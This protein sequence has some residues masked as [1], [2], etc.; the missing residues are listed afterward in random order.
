MNS[1]TVQDAKNHLLTIHLEDYFQVGT[2]RSVI[3][4]QHWYRFETRV[5]ENTYKTLDLLDEF[6][7]KATFFS[8]GWVADELPEVL[9]EV[10]RRGHEIAS[11]GYYHR[12][13]REMT[14]DE[15]RNDL[16]RSR[17]AIERASGSKVHGYRSAR[18]WF[19]PADLWALDILAEEGFAY[20]S[21]ICP[22]FRGY[23]HEP[24]RRFA[25]I[26]RS[27]GRQIWEFPLSTWSFG[28][29]CLPI[30]GGNYH[31][32]IPHFLM[33][34][35]VARWDRQSDSPFVMYFHVWELDPGQPRIKAAPLYQRIRQYRNLGKMAWLVPEYLS[36]Y[37]FI[38][39]ADHLGLSRVPVHESLA[40]VDGGR[41]SRIRAV[42][43]PPKLSMPTSVSR[44][45]RKKVT[46]VVPCY[47]EESSL[48]YLANTLK[49]VEER[50]AD[51]YEL[52]YVFVDDS[53]SD[54][55]WEVL[56]RIFG[57]RSECDLL[58]H[59]KNLG[60]AAAILSG[61]RNSKT[62][63]VC[64]I[65]CD[66][67]YDPHQLE[68]MLPLLEDGVDLVTASPY[69]PLGRVLNVP[70]WRLALSKT[71]SGLYGLILPQKLATYT[72]CFRVYRRSVVAEVPLKEGGFLGVAELVAM[73]DLYGC[74]IV[75]FP[76]VLEVRLL[77]Q[78]KMKIVKTILGHLGLLSRIWREKH[79]LKKSGFRSS[80]PW[81]I[82]HAIPN[83]AKSA[84][85]QKTVEGGNPHS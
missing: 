56:Q 43:T 50:L 53:S 26:H 81:P 27:G 49:S 51:Q 20:D 34:R 62:E 2:L 71:L 77:G 45:E 52:R 35:A 68:A 46:L 13:I 25:H 63:I 74:K 6:G 48:S 28:G 11:K 22:L 76:A 9:R 17:E 85:V 41:E 21:S 10:A 14:P 78:S 54:T 40:L 16:R 80:R 37:S 33:K 5:A 60:V 57:S 67:T 38:G 55:T 7:I 82:T 24:W 12:S 4:P 32:Q 15:F 69:H 64:S 36:R 83:E 84:S 8:L 18:G 47:N 39:I 73:L 72:S 59:P 79:R 75:E 70:G 31:R 23:A 1:S 61:L 42:Q 66:C 3:P 44:Q 30:A 58:R 65:D 29:W 19:G